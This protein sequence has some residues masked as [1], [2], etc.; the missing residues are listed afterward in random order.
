[1]SAGAQ[2]EVIPAVF[3]LRHDSWSNRAWQGKKAEMRDFSALLEHGY[4][5]YMTKNISR[6]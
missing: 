1:M 4:A 6:A 2:D 5:Q 3:K